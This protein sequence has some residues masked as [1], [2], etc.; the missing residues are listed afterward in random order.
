MLK[1]T[2]IMSQVTVIMLQVM[3]IMLQVTI[4]VLQL[5]VVVSQVTSEIPISRKPYGPAH[6][7]PSRTCTPNRSLSSTCNRAR[8]V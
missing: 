1:V 7:Q 2:V 6:M 4:T 3:V 8:I 5:T